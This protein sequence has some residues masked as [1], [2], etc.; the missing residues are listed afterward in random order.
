MTTTTKKTKPKATM[1]EEEV[2]TVYEIEAV[3]RRRNLFEMDIEIVTEDEQHILDTFHTQ[4]VAVTGRSAIGQFATDHIGAMAAH[5]AY[6]MTTT[7]EQ[8]HRCETA[9]NVGRFE[10]RLQNFNDRLLDD[11][12]RHALEVSRIAVQQMYAD[13]RTTIYSEKS[14]TRPKRKGLMRG[15]QEFLFGEE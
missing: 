2:T 13:T 15:F 5:A 4:A 1:F 3:P 8:I 9:A 14:P 10:K 11:T 6:M 7:T 12:G